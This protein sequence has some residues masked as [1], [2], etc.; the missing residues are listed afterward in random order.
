MTEEALKRAGRK[1]QELAAS[2]KLTATTPSR[3][4]P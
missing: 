1:Y 4:S 2:E 3:L